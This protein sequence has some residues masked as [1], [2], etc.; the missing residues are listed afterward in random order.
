MH[1]LVTLASVVMLAASSV[2]CANSPERSTANML[3]PSSSDG[4]ATVGAAGGHGGSGGGKPG[5]GSGTRGSLAV[6]M[7]IDNNTDGV[8]SFGDTVTFTVS[9]TATAYPWVTLRCNQNGTLVSQE[10]NGIFATS[11]SRDFTLGPTSLW[12]SGAATCTA[13]LEN[14]DSY[15]KNGSITVLASTS[16]PVN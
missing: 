9:T 15:S 1:R 5:G 8:P 11:L 14:W 2:N 16:F 3:A 4:A 6:A 10:S 13:T 12:P 7:V